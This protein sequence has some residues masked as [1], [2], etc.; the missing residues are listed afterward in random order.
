MDRSFF[1]VTQRDPKFNKVFS[2]GMGSNAEFFIRVFIKERGYLFD[3]FGGGWRWSWNTTAMAIAEAF[4][5]MHCSVLD[6]HQVVS[7]VKNRSSVEFIVGDMFD[8]VPSTTTNVVLL[9]VNILRGC[10]IVSK[11]TF[12]Y[13]S[14]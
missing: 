6:L 4:L 11:L 9:K 5:T 14:V 7:S 12:S 3:T 8:Y 13:L 1:E 2:E 10:L